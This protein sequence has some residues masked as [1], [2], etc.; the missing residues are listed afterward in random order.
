MEVA[1]DNG[2][3]GFCGEVRSGMGASNICRLGPDDGR[4]A[5]FNENCELKSQLNIVVRV[6]DIPIID[7]ITKYKQLR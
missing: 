7:V 2:R 6:V 1:S 4:N 5:Q 3:L